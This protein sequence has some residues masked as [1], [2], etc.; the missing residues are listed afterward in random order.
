MEHATTMICN[1]HSIFFLHEKVL[2]MCFV[3]FNFFFYYSLKEESGL[4]CLCACYDCLGYRSV[5]VVSC[6]ICYRG[7]TVS[8]SF[9]VCVLG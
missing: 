3:Q 8:I 5:K 2:V 1:W 4:V 7:N 9:S 6:I